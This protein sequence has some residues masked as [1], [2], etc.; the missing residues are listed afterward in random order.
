MAYV[1]KGNLTNKPM[2]VFLSLLTLFYSTFALSQDKLTNDHLQDSLVIFKDSNKVKPIVLKQGS[3]VK[4][5]GAGQHA[6]E[7]HVHELSSDTLIL[8][9]EI[10]LHYVPYASIKKLSV[11]N[12]GHKQL[13]SALLIQKGFLALLPVTAALIVAFDQNARSGQW[14]NDYTN[15]AQTLGIPAGL[16][17]LSGEMMRWKKIKLAGTWTIR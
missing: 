13:F 1:D 17:M 5:K 4:I 9:S 11:F 8:V 2:K 6:L 7:G 15:I 10:G 14:P 16:A 3:R 12:Y